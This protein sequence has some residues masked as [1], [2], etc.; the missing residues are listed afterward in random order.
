VRSRWSPC[1]SSSRASIHEGTDNRH[2]DSTFGSVSPSEASRF[3]RRR[4]RGPAMRSSA[5]PRQ[6]RLHATSAKLTSPHRVRTEMGPGT[7]KPMDTN[8]LVR[9]VRAGPRTA[10]NRRRAA[11]RS[12]PPR[13]VLVN[14]ASTRGAGQSP[15]RRRAR[16]RRSHRRST[17]AASRR[18]QGDR[19]A[20][21]ADQAAGQQTAR[22]E[23]RHGSLLPAG[24]PGA[25]GFE[26]T[27]SAAVPAPGL[28]PGPADRHGF[29]GS[30]APAGGRPA[31]RPCPYCY[32][33]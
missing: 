18:P 4:C 29:P 22:D 33:P 16:G 28:V 8:A 26:P 9:H 1:S 25:R 24:L 31:E 21:D 2:H 6:Q 10:G 13:R 3:T 20:A 12:C 5:M 17:R 30:R 32:L 7:C 11:G 14:G 19:L 27:R 15:R 23:A